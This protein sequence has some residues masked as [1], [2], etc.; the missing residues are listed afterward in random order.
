MTRVSCV[1]I[2]LINADKPPAALAF[3]A[4]ACERAQ[5]EY[6]CISLNTSFLSRFD[7]A[8][9]SQI[10]NHVIK[11]GRTESVV[12]ILDPALD[13]VIDAIKAHESTVILISIFSYMQHDLAEYFLNRVR[14]QLVGIT[15]VAGGPGVG[16]GRHNMRSEHST[17]GQSL[18]DQGLVDF[19]CLGEG[20]QVLPRFLQGQQDSAGMNHAQSARE[21]WVPQIDDL[22]QH[23]LIPSYK[24]V[25]VDCY[26]NLEN[27][28]SA[29]YSLSTS[30]GCVRHCAFCDIGKTWKKFRFRSGEHIAQEILQH[31]NDV[32]AVHFHFVDSLINGSLKSFRDLNTR[33]VDFRARYP[34]LRDLSY[35]GMFIVRDRHSHPQELF[36]SM[37]AAGC[38][39][40]AIGVETGS[41]RLRWEM[42]KKFTNQDLDWHLEMCSRYGIKNVFLMFVAYPTE[43]RQD[44]E[45]TLAM[46]DRYQKYLVDDTILGI[47]CAGVFSLLES[48]PVFDNR[49][50]LGIT[51]E[52]DLTNNKL[53][54]HNANNP[55]LT[56]RER[57]MRDLEFRQHA[58]RLRYP[59]PYARRYMQ[60]LAEI[61]SDFVLQ[62][63]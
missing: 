29:V 40:L 22:D 19:Y 30:R 33:L 62:S 15:I 4:A 47:N 57:I 8:T 25:Q 44:F 2:D 55:D 60:Y 6:E 54:W 31:H 58:L 49:D 34:S 41:D 51:I 17:F 39:S 63:D 45:Q 56:R 61:D 42:N 21:T 1:S 5:V 3:M 50:A 26:H 35:N 18:L 20:D 12:E 14:R 16:V 10:Y 36:A 53:Q 7:S 23:Y 32:G 38:E 24:K 37:A 52:H 59:I 27:K 43:T 9:M 46:L 48:T 28:N 13:Q 11:L